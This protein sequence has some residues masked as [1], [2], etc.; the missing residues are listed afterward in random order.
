TQAPALYARPL[1][2]DAGLSLIGNNLRVATM[3]GCPTDVT[4][5][6]IFASAADAQAMQELLRAVNPAGRPVAV[7]VTQNS[8]GQQTGWHVDRFAAVI[9]HAERRGF[10]VVYVG[11]TAEQEAIDAV[12][13]AADGIG[14]SVAGRTTVSELVALLAMS[15]VMVTL[16]TGTMHVGRAAGVPMVILGPSWQ[17]PIEWMPLGVNNVR[18][19]R[20]PD[21]DNVPD[22][23]RLDEIAAE[24]ATAA[25][26]DLLKAHPPSMEARRARVHESLSEIDHLAVRGL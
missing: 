1:A 3:L 14:I 9:R 21:T 12:R 6:R 18:I 16:D 26:E 5:P 11:T 24:S 17:K 7:F 15:D 10:A 23:Y 2:Y 20:G 8:R 19:L 4:R 22:G 25:M 13:G